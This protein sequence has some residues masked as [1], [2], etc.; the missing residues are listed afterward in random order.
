MGAHVFSAIIEQPGRFANKHKLWKYSQLSITD[1]SSDN[2]P[3]GYQ[4]LDRRG[5]QELKISPTTPGERLANRP[6]GQ[7]R[8]RHFINRAGFAPAVCGTPDSTLS[9]RFWRQCG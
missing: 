6:L 5:N 1:R 4:R 9:A 2:K 8:S 7:M 3:L